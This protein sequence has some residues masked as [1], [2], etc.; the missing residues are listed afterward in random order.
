MLLPLSIL[1]VALPVGAETHFLEVDTSIMY[2][3][4]KINNF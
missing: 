2:D 3:Y 1:K 4:K